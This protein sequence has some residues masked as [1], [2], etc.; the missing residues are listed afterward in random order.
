MVYLQNILLK[1]AHKVSF[2]YF[3]ELELILHKIDTFAEYSH[4]SKRKIHR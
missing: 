3:I 4:S 2:I 1:A